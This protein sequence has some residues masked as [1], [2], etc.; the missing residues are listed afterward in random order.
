MD[1]ERI[2]A[3]WLAG[4]FLL[5]P[6]SSYSGVFLN[7]FSEENTFL[8]LSSCKKFS[9]SFS[10]KSTV[11]TETSGLKTIQT[12]FCNSFYDFKI[13]VFSLRIEEKNFDP[14]FFVPDFYTNPCTYLHY[15]PPRH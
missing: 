8:L 7:S 6:F 9:G 13:P 11:Q 14:I 12:S 10:E 4:I 15:N 2:I 1:K 3:L 5:N